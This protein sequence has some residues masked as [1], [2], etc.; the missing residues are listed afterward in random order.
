[1]VSLSPGQA[2]VKMMSMAGDNQ[3]TQISRHD[4][5][6]TDFAMLFGS[7]ILVTKTKTETKK[8]DFSKTIS[9]TKTEM[10]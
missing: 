9:K 8:I 6:P 7:D 3:S 5:N 1:M 4:P 10:I 2:P